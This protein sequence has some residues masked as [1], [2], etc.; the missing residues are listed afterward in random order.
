MSGLFGG[1]KSSSTTANKLAGIQLMTSTYGDPIPV[2][3]GTPRIPGKL[4]YYQ[5]FTAIPHTQ[6][7]K[8]GK[9]GGSTMSNTTYTYTVAAILVL[10]EGQA[11][12]I[13]RFWADKDR[14]D[15]P[16]K[17][18][19]TFFNGAASQSPWGYVTSKHPTE[20]IGY[21]GMVY[22][23]HPTL[24][25]GDS[26]SMKNLSFEVRTAFTDHPNGKDALVSTV[27]N[28]V[29]TQP[30][31]GMGW[32]SSRINAAAYADFAA[33]CLA[34]G[35]GISPVF[36]AQKPAIDWINDLLTVANA[37]AI[38][39][40]GELKFI[41]YQDTPVGGWTPNT[42]PIYDLGMDD[43]IAEPGEDP[44]KVTRSTQADA[45][46]RVQVE[47]VNRDNDHA[48]EVAEA[49]DQA[50][51]ETFG[52]RSEDPIQL[53]M[54]ADP[55]IAQPVAQRALQRRLYVRNVYEFRL[56][57]RHM[58]LE[59]MD[60]V[61]LTAPYLGLD[62]RPARIFE[63]ED[64]EDG[65]I[66]VKAEE[67]P[68]GVASATLYPS[69]SGTGGTVDVNADPG[70]VTSWAAFEAP[71]TL[72][73]GRVEVWL[74]AAGGPNWG[75]AEV[76]TSR[77]GSSYVMAG[78]INAPARIGILTTT[79]PAA[80]TTQG[81]DATTFAIGQATGQFVSLSD[82][83]AAKFAG[84]SW[85]NSELFSYQDAALLGAGAYELRK[86]RRGLHGTAAGAHATGEK[87][88]RCDD[89]LLHLDAQDWE[90]GQ[91]VFIKFRSF[92]LVGAQKQDLA[93]LSAASFTIQGL[94]RRW[95]APSSC[96]VTIDAN[97]NTGGNPGGG[98]T[99]TTPTL[100]GPIASIRYSTVTFPLSNQAGAIG[101]TGE[102]SLSNSGSKAV[103]YLFTL[104][105]QSNVRV[106]MLGETSLDTFVALYQADSTRLAFNDDTG[107]VYKSEVYVQNLPAG[108]YVVECTTYVPGA[109]GT[110]TLSLGAS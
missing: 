24:D 68:F 43:F 47:F 30:R 60:L 31:Y 27:I 37:A 21:G 67:W 73:E 105:A 23:A 101:S 54:I 94:V 104:A 62:K 93:T 107:A 4:V 77:D 12:G 53:H 49:S 34:A 41:P 87:V 40:G 97:P 3:Y 8:V 44:I 6:T 26:G 58:L 83:D 50:N 33:Y 90:V 10:Q 85:I 61:T 38:P 103:Y 51:I 19:F 99:P 65:T 71:G 72:T 59:G 75:G 29:L 98:T 74:G 108:T 92:N 9:G 88:L 5:D 28:D 55:T 7:Q 11:V 64:A 57:P 102:P 14:E 25:L 109:T 2:A 32:S 52:L 91:T 69:A 70:N 36:D 106:T 22:L 95:P 13:N 84:L 82:A 16:S 15:I 76:W 1:G 48:A 96:S 46:N 80:G 78:T 20:A 42:T 66:E 110:F 39:S 86:N 79:T 63:T 45:F 18:G 56:G 100:S 89:A 35:I 17:G 81:V